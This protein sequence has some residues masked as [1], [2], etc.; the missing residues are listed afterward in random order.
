[1]VA[2]GLSE[3]PVIPL[4]AMIVSTAIFIHGTRLTV[5]FFL[6]HTGVRIPVRV[7]S[8]PAWSVARPAVYSLIEDVVA[9]N[10]G[11]G[12]KYREELNARYEAS[13]AF[14]R[15]LNRMDGFWGFGALTTAAVVS[16]L[17]W[18]LPTV[19]IYWIGFAGPFIWATVWAYLTLRYVRSCLA[20]EKAAW[21]RKCKSLVSFDRFETI[22]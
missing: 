2:V 22:H 14:R 10:G 1:M 8:L 5:A 6:Y 15:M 19:K 16:V 3:Q 7:S 11:G 4:F 17:L 20:K 18:T 21:K 12:T 13:P 9:V